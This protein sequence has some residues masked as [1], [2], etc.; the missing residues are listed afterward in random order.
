MTST[1]EPKPTNQAVDTQPPTR[2]CVLCRQ[3]QQVVEQNRIRSN[4]RRFRGETF[5]VWRCAGCSSLHARDDVDLDHYYSGYPIFTAQLDWRLRVVYDNMLARL[6]RAGVRPE[7]RVLDYG[8][9]AGLLV[10]HLRD[11]GYRDVHGFDRYAEGM[12]KPELLQ[13][14]YDGIV[15]QDVLEHV[16]DPH[17]L[18]AEFDRMVKPGGFVVIGTPDGATLR[19]NNY[20]QDVHA[21]HQPYHRHILSVQA[22]HAAGEARG[23]SVERHYATMFNNTL[24][25]TMNPRFVLHYVKA[26]DDVFDLVAEPI[27]LTGWKIWSPLTPFY[28][29]FGYFFDRHTD[30]M[31]V[32]RKP[33]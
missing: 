23:W 19:L 14:L 25:P 2:F 16:D 22:L 27:K 24:F 17:A 6:R 12:N 33:G 28:A 30:I 8:C 32:F 29:L 20:E 3:P 26:H 18:L 7:H 13:D 21:L 31:T 15:S 1:Q 4:V 9:G 10:Q 11:R 5:A